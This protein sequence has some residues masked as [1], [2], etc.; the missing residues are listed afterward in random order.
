MKKFRSIVLLI[1]VFLIP[2]FIIFGAGLG[3]ISHPAEGQVINS[4]LLPLDQRGYTAILF[5]GYVGCSYICPASLYK[6]DDLLKEK[7]SRSEH[8]DVTVLFADVANRPGMVTADSYAKRISSRMAG[9]NLSEEQLEYAVKTFNLRIRDSKNMNKEVFHTDHFFVLK[10]NGANYVVTAVLP[11]QVS[12]EALSDA[13]W[14][15]NK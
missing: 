11:N 13:I 15:N 4:D 3:S 7:Q 5:F 9:V 12:S 10:R 2:I 14:P 1:S 6:I 8:S